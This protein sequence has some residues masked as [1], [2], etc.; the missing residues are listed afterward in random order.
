MNGRNY[1]TNQFLHKPDKWATTSSPVLLQWAEDAYTQLVYD[2]T[3]AM[4]VPGCIQ[5]DRVYFGMDQAV[6]A[7]VWEVLENIVAWYQHYEEILYEEVK[8]K[9][10]K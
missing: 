4:E 10:K 5:D 7:P 9:V 6:S 2:S 8:P 3:V 1:E